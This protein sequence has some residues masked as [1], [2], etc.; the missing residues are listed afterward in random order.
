MPEEGRSMAEPV[1]V[2]EAILAHRESMAQVIAAQSAIEQAGG[3]VAVS[4][5]SPKG[6][7]L[8]TLT[9][10]DPYTPQDFLPGLPFYVI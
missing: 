8:V 7:V 4:L 10:P 2:Y 9:L 6:L 3:S 5:P 1:S